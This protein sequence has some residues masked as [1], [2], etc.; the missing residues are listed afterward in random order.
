[1]KIRFPKIV[2]WKLNHLYTE[3]R[4][5]VNLYL[6]TSGTCRKGERLFIYLLFVFIIHFHKSNL[7]NSI[8]CLIVYLMQTLPNVQFYIRELHFRT[9]N[10]REILSASAFWWKFYAL[11]VYSLLLLQVR[12]K[13]G[14]MFTF[15]E[16]NIRLAGEHVLF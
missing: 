3:W 9:L 10:G 15:V 14:K 2:F 13:H 4:Q 7:S 1:M 12:W 6:M 5:P 11:K 16:D 8:H